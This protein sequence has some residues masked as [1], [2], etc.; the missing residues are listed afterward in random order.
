MFLLQ[1]LGEDINALWLPQLSCADRD[2][3]NTLYSRHIELIWV[4][5]SGILAVITF[6]KI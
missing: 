6:F 2:V 4:S 3:M 5:K 1:L